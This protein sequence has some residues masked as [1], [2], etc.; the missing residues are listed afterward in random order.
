[1]SFPLSPTN[2][3]TTLLNGITYA[4]NSVDNAWARVPVSTVISS[5]ATVLN[6]LSGQCDGAKSVFALK[7]DQTAVSGIVD[8]KDLEVLVNG[9]KTTPYV[10]E[11]RYPWFTPYDGY[12]GF[13]AVTTGTTDNWL[14]IY[15]PPELGSQVTVTQLNTSVRK[16]SRRYP[17]SATSIALGD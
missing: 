11:T 14:V 10:T 2:G 15:N 16:Q 17:Y 3:Q 6:D 1:M 7:I 8:S 9:V 4:F 13:R 5:A 12:R